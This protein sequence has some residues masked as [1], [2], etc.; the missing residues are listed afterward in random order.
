MNKNKREKA[1]RDILEKAEKANI[2]GYAYSGLAILDFNKTTMKNKEIFQDSIKYMKKLAKK[3]N[4]LKKE[5]KKG[6]IIQ[7]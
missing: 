2:I 1:Y 5:S 6:M 7:I 4:L 3:H